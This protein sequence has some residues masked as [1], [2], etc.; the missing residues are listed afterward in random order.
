MTLAYTLLEYGDGKVEVSGL[1]ILWMIALAIA[2][3]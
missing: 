1:F 2:C 3:R